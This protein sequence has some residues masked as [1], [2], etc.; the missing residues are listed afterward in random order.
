MILIQRIFTAK[1][2]HPCRRD[3]GQG[4]TSFAI[5]FIENVPLF[6]GACLVL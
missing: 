1:E 2:E 5:R 4:A 3:M 6:R